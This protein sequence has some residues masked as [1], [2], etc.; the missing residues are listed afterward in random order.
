MNEG[1]SMKTSDHRQSM[2]LHNRLLVDETVL[3]REALG[4][5]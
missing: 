2:T 5:H 3:I 1:K 4:E